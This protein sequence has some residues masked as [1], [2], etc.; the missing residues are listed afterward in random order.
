MLK[1]R[2]PAGIGWQS[3]S[4]S[5][6][7]FLVT[8]TQIAA[9]NTNDSSRVIDQRLDEAETRALLEDVHSAYHTQINDILLTALAQTMMEW[10]QESSV[11]F[12]LEGHGREDLFEDA[13]VTRT[14][15]W[16]TSVFPVRL[17]YKGTMTPGRCCFR[18]RNSCVLFLITALAMG[19]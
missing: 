2:A 10:L 12:A 17:E 19:C 9:F 11:L 3:A 8:L 1:E 5:P 6:S 14:A 15:G 13:N 16:F 4:G 7:S 18:S